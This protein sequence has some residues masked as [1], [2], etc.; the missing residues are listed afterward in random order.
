MS[1]TISIRAASGS[2]SDR[3][4]RARRNVGSSRGDTG[5]FSVRFVALRPT[6]AR[7]L[8]SHFAFAADVT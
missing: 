8:G 5:S 7:V 2:T 3:H 1:S 4:R 6:M